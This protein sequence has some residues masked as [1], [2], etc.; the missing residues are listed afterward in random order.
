MLFTL[1]LNGPPFPAEGDYPYFLGGDTEPWSIQ[2]LAQP[3]R[4]LWAPGQVVSEPQL[5]C[6][7]NGDNN[8][9]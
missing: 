4:K 1:L 6:L 5:P 3:K 7:Y 9:P 8:H 2:I